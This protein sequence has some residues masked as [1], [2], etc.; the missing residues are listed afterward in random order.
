MMEFRAR[1]EKTEGEGGRER[2]EG[3]EKEGR[4]EGVREEGMK[5]RKMS[6]LELCHDMTS[7]SFIL[8]M[9]QTALDGL[10]CSEK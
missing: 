8:V 2:K 9:P 1:K 3:G 7:C 5:N 6:S 4:G 10:F